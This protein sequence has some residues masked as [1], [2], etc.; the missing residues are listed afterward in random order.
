MGGGLAGVDDSPFSPPISQGV[1]SALKRAAELTPTVAKSA[2][3][4][5]SC[6]E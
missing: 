5:M 4:A 2:K 3:D 6:A 1:D